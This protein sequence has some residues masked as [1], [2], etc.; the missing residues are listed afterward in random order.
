MKRCFIVAFSLLCLLMPLY[1]TPAQQGETPT[2]DSGAGAQPEDK[3]KT[4]EGKSPEKANEGYAV[5]PVVVTATRTETP[6]SETTKSID[7]VD[8]KQMQVQQQTYMPETLNTVPGVMFEQEGGPGQYS[9]INIRGAGTEHVQFQ[10]NGIPLRD[11]TDTQ[12]TLQYFTQDLYGGGGIN[13]VEVL[14]GTNSTLYGSAAMGGVVNIIPQKWQQGFS[15]EVRSEMGQHNTFIENGAFSYGQDNYYINFNPTYIDTDG[16]KNG[17]KYGYYYNNFGFTGGGGV[18][19]FDNMTFEVGSISYNSD[20]ALSS[21]LPALD[22]NHNLITNEASKD[23][24]RESVMNLT[25]ATLTHQVSSLWDYTVKAAYGQTERHYFWS[26]TAGD[27]SNYDG[28]T[29]YIETQHNVHPTDWMTLTMGFDYDEALYAGRDPLDPY[30]GNYTPVYYDYNWFGYDLFSQAQLAFFDKSLFITGGMR[31]NDHEQFDSKVVEEGSAAYIFKPTGTKIHAAFGTGYRTPSL[32]EIYG[33]YLYNGQ[34]ITIGN[35]DLKPEESTSFEAGVNQ[36]FLDNKINVG[37]TWFHIDFDDQILY[38]GFSN[39]YKNATEGKSQGI[40]AK[41]ETKPCRY[42]SLGVAYTYADSRYRD[43]NTSEWTRTEYWPMNT[44]TFLGT[45]YPIDRLSLSCKVTWESDKIVPLYDTSYNKVRYEES[46][47]GRVDLAAT[48]KILKNYKF[49]N[50][51][52][53]FMRVENLLD[54]DY[55]E[56]GYLMPGR[57]V[58]GGLKMSF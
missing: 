39:K 10:Y 37:V 36:P 18:R 3:G 44:L 38:D 1:S 6:L 55:T 22:A 41:I 7:V 27:R 48:Y 42:F 52:D 49:V 31:Y 2:T 32:Y 16:A 28:S 50:D 9:G 4:T 47:I 57:W 53:L 56:G 12:N 34:L 26:S 23:E 35:P 46:G 40:E 29:T 17:G 58:Y 54:A 30:S 51:I 33:G 15:S 11:A 13:R 19:I 45:V 5:E 21:I 25:G 24:H 43:Y 8:R 14:R 20:L